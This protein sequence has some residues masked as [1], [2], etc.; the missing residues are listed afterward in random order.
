MYVCFG[1]SSCAP[2][3]VHYCLLKLGSQGG[4]RGL[5]HSLVYDGTMLGGHYLSTPGD[6]EHEGKYRILFLF[7]LFLA[8]IIT[9]SIYA[10]LAVI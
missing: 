6:G 2:G 7:F 3:L 9:V 1:S 4:C 8:C 10:S 5:P